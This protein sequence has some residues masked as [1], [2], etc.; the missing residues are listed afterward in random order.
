MYDLPWV[1]HVEIVSLAVQHFWLNGLALSLINTHTVSTCFKMVINCFSFQ[2]NKFTIRADVSSY[3]PH[4]YP[5][6]FYE[7]VF[8]LQL[9]CIIVTSW[10][11]FFH[12]KL[13]HHHNNTI[14]TVE[15]HSS[16]NLANI[17]R[18][19]LDM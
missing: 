4:I 16:T 3:T 17:P 19:H 2:N 18:H 8:K 1:V 12:L 5:T 9:L 13:I 15:L 14:T 7:Y 6:K 10:L 11:M